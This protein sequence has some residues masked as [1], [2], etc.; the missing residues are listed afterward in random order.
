M[1][2]LFQLLVTQILGIAANLELECHVT[3]GSNDVVTPLIPVNIEPGFFAFGIGIPLGTFI[4][5]MAGEG[6]DL[7]IT[8]SNPVSADGKETISFYD[9]L[10]NTTVRLSWQTQGQPAYTI[11]DD[12]VFI[13]CVE[14]MTNY[15]DLRDE[16]QWANEGMDSASRVRAY[17]RNWNVFLRA[18]GPNSCDTIRLIKSMLLEDW[19][20]DQL[21]SSRLYLTGDMG[22]PVRAPE[23]FEGQ[24]WEQVDVSCDFFEEIFESYIY[25]PVT[26]VEIVGFKDTG[27]IFDIQPEIL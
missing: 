11:D 1:D 10:A 18:R 4:Q 2:V 8:L 26:S 27:E 17:T 24:W 22:T 21:A 3:Y 23:L 9:S 20:H 6:T 5:N 12:V 13:R 7:I 19:T 16:T 15:S 25:E 14:V